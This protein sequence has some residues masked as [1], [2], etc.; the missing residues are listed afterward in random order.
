MSNRPRT[1]AAQG[2]TALLRTAAALGAAALV[3][4]LAVPAGASGAPAA[5]ARPAPTVPQ[6]AWGS[7]GDDAALA[8][9]ECAEVEVPTDHDRPRGA[10]TTI[11][12]TRLP[13]TDPDQRIGTLF[14]NPGGPGGSGVDFVQAAGEFAWTPEVRA[15][16]DVLGFDPRGVGASGPT[17]CFP[18]AAREA[19]FLARQQVTFPWLD[20][21]ENR[22]TLNSAKLGASCTAT[23]GDR[24]AHMSTA[25]VARD[26]DLLRQAVG[27]EKLSYVGYSYGTYLGATYAKLFPD[28]VR[29]LVLDGTV[30]PAAYS[31][32]DGDRRPVTLRMDQHTGGRDVLAEFHAQC[33]EAG[34]EACALAALGDPATVTEELLQGLKTAPVTLP[35][36]DGTEL[37][38][39]YDVAVTGTFFSLYEPTQW[40]A[41]AADLAAMATAQQAG[42]HVATVSAQGGS[43]GFAGWLRKEDFVSV[44]TNFTICAETAESGTPLQ[45]GRYSDEAEAEAPHFG[46]L[47]A[48]A[49]QVCEYV[50]VVDRDAYVGPWDQD[51]D[52]P[53][54]VIGTRFDPATPYENTQPYA[55]RFPDARVLTLDGWGHTIL[56]KS[57]CADEAVA[58]YLVDLEATDGAVCAPDAAPFDAPVAPAA[59]GAAPQQVPA[60]ELPQQVPVRPTVGGPGL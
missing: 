52:S 59:R 22:F 60:T 9:F 31:G 41:L 48:W 1:A 50:P 46:A 49:P 8:A 38:V 42:T 19:A 36:P 54:M 14:T 53:V 10:T 57:A 17:T 15:R 51:V 56:F 32:S 55:D 12:L 28:T 4:T 30:E 11:A 2:R 37:E 43:A 34:A 26:M 24:L 47:R 5:A 27:D 6:I 44:G 33:A 35:L 40:P 21:Q 39:T 7:C 23:S 16:F 25:N 18:T 45:Y 20:R 29:A 13:A 58:R 3:S